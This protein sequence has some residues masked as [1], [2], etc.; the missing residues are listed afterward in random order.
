MGEEE[1]IIKLESKF[2]KELI[3]DIKERL[4]G[5]II[6][7]NDPS[8]IQGMP[9]LTILWN[10]RWAVLE[11]KRAKNSPLQPNQ[12]YYVDVLNKMSYSRIVYP[13]NKEEILNELQHTLG[14]S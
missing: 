5:C 2:Q 13:D 6:L 9:D 10:Y 1:H 14:S 12:K 8:Y 11:V 7:K 3:D 4:P